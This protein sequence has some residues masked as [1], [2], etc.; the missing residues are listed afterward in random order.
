MTHLI[1]SLL[2]QLQGSS[3]GDAVRRAEFLYPVLESIHILGIA[4]LVGPAIS[5]DLRLLG[6]GYRSVSVTTA[7]RNLL[8][9]SHFGFAITVITGVALLSAQASVV[10]QAGAAPW[11]LGLLVLACINVLVFHFGVY[12]RVAEWPDASKAPAAARAGAA[13]SIVSWSGVILAGRL[14]AYT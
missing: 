14:L 4:L 11:K 6:I 8:P 1:D 9:V 2:S 13:V 3:L 7:A 5:F 12:R 10:A